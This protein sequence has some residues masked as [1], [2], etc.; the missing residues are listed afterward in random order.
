MNQGKCFTGKLPL[1]NWKKNYDANIIQYNVA[2]YLI[3]FWR[4]PYIGAQN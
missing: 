3:M 1:A 2:L 4:F